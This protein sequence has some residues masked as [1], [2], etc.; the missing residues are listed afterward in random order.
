[1]DGEAIQQV[2]LYSYLLTD[3]GVAFLEGRNSAIETALPVSL[4]RE[5]ARIGASAGMNAALAEV[6]FANGEQVISVN[7]RPTFEKSRDLFFENLRNR[8]GTAAS[9]FV[10]GDMAYLLAERFDTDLERELQTTVARSEEVLRVK[11]SPVL[12]VKQRLGRS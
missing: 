5:I 2:D 1:M 9:L 4:Q 11:L 10:N 3:A 7:G 12:T 6:R 8:L